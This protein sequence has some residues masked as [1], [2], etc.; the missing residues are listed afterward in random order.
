VLLGY[1]AM[2]W[3]SPDSWKRF[4]LNLGDFLRFARSSDRLGGKSASS[5]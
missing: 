5:P 1:V 2:L 4:L 3:R